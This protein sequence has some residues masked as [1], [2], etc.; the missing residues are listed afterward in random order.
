MSRYIATFA[1]HYDALV[2]KKQLDALSISAALRPVPR[3]L[4]SSCGT[5]VRFEADTCP[6]PPYPTETEQIV[7]EEA[8][9]FFPEYIAKD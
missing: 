7:R 8:D 2:F 5:C 6:P 3:Q 4:S 9:G 1:S